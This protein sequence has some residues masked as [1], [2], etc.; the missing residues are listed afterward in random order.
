MER[1]PV[2]QAKHMQRQPLSSPLSPEVYSTAAQPRWPGLR[3]LA[4]RRYRCSQFSTALG[5]TRLLLRLSVFPAHSAPV[6][7]VIAADRHLAR[8]RHAVPAID[9][10]SSTKR[11]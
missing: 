10:T 1:G 5:S 9:L 7:V 4:S 3:V 8:R 6:G 11:A 2:P